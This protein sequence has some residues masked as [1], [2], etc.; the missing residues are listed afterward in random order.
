MWSPAALFL[1]LLTTPPTLCLPC[2]SFKRRHC[3]DT[4]LEMGFDNVAAQGAADV[5]GAHAGRAVQLLTEYGSFA[6]LAPKPADV[7]G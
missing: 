7:T 2:Y 3:V 4:L 6:G 1:S 5:T